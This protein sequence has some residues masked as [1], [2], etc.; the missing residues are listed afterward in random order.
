MDK[1]LVA[2]LGVEDGGCSIYGRQADGSWSFWQEGSSTDF[3]DEEFS[4]SWETE[5]V[6]DLGLAVPKEWTLYHVLKI[7]PEFVGWFRDHY[8]ESKGHLDPSLREMQAEYI[9]PRWAEFLGL[10]G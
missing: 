4:R 7:D 6:L 8:E 2:E 5:P 1:V 10:P 9:H 3:A